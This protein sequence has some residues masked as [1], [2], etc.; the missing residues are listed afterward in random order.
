MNVDPQEVQK[1]DEMAIDWWDRAGPCKPLHDLNPIRLGFIQSHCQLANQQ[2]LDIGCGGGI[3]TE[4]LTPFS[5]TVWGIDQSPKALE[6]ARSHSLALKNPPRYELITA[7]DFANDS[8]G[9]FDVITCMELLEHVPSPLSL[10]EACAKLLKPN[11]HLFFSTL[12]RTPKAFLFAIIGAEYVMKL[13][14]KRTHEFERFIRP[15]ELAEW[16]R[17][18]QL[19]LQHLKGISYQLLSKS[20]HLSGDVS[21]NYIMHLQKA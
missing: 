5:T 3:L 19:S 9:Y 10:I 2:V 7:E 13:L 12:N 6:V 11:G 14:P 20:Y 18:Y 4:A 16:A 21:V 8:P 17:R 1:F 15:S